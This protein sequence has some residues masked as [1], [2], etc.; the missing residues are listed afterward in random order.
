MPKFFFDF[1][2]G[3]RRTRDAEG[4]E[5]ANAESAKREAMVAV[6]QVLQLEESDDD[7]RVV[8]CRVRDS[9]DNEVY[10]VSLAFNGAW[11]GDESRHP[12][13]RSISRI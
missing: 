12:R 4:L 2:D 6:A 3:A 5:L 11:A 7:R 10:R 8:E 13:L 9:R 1:R